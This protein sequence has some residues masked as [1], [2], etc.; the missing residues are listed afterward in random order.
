[1]RAILFRPADSL[2]TDRQCMLSRGIGG[3]HVESV[4]SLMDCGFYRAV[5]L[6]R[7]FEDAESAFDFLNSE[8]NNLADSMS[9]GDVLIWTNGKR[10]LCLN[11]GWADL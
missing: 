4:R 2:M 5:G 1:M 8:E 11:V 10:E 6:T 7:D 3:D 9:V